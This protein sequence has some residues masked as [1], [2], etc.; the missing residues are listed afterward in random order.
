MH[1]EN[2][3]AIKVFDARHGFKVCMGAHYLGG[4]TRDNKSKR[5]FMIDRTLMWDKNIGTIIKT[6]GKYPQE[7][8]AAVARAIQ[9]EC[10]FLKLVIWDTGGVFA[11]VEKM[12][13]ETFLP[14]LFL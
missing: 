12:I 11:G 7:S 14:R 3:E 8:Y 9:A 5:D 13:R 6:A 4:Y 2:L 10:I 1:L